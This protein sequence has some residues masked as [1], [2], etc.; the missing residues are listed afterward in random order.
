[1]SLFVNLGNLPERILRKSFGHVEGSGISGILA[2]WINLPR[3][4]LSGDIR[5]EFQANIFKKTMKR[6]DKIT[7]GHFNLKNF[8]NCR[9]YY[10]TVM[11]VVAHFITAEKK[12]LSLKVN[13]FIDLLFS[14]IPV[15]TYMILLCN[16]FI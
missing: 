10:P 9:N 3:S 6:V 12:E 13:Y 8:H 11:K 14:S 16:M 2:F 4:S 1:M 15:Y 7:L 5:T